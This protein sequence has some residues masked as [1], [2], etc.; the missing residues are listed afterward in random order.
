MNGRKDRNLKF[1]DG[2]WYLD[3]T[4]RGRRVRKF[5]GF[6][7]D[8]AKVALAKE[9][10]DRRDIELGLKKPPAEDVTFS[11]FADEYI[12]LYAKPNKKSWRGD[13]NILEGLKDY[14]KGDS[15]KSITA[16]KIQRFV[17][18]RR[19]EKSKNNGH[20]ISPS[21]VNR[22]LALLKT[23]FAKAV[24]WGRIETNP[25]ARVKKLKEPNGRER[26]LTHEEAHRLL[27]AASP[28]FRPILI[29]AL[30][31]GMRRGEILSLRWTDLDLV[32]GIITITAQK[33]GKT[34]KIPISGTVAEALGGVSRRG[35]FVFWN[36][37][38]G[39]HLKDVKTAFRATCARAKITD[40]RF[41]DL[42][43]TAFSWM[44]QAGV[45]ITTI[46]KIARHAS[47]EM[48]RRY[49]HERPEDQR[50]AVGILGEI[51]DSTRQK[52]ERPSKS[53]IKPTHLT[54]TNLNH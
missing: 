17:A 1:N 37:E 45:K 25:A 46:Q 15:L 7:K 49:I 52:D 38:T 32:R 12:E 40:V 5:G 3:F 31:T 21:T 51:L 47:I 26:F 30:G 36:E 8:Q 10:L 19:V 24:E 11:A 53:I 29:V 14:F 42:R 48:T 23:L 41:H 22:A 50:E 39:T 18:E 35:E 28:D 43:H 33:N 6:T 44:D 27:A 13:E 34:D 16:E 20:T 54:A 9:R 4:H 2:K